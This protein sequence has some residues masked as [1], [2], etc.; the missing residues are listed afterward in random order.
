MTTVAVILSPSVPTHFAID[1]DQIDS[2]W[3]LVL[4]GDS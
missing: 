3:D 1:L 2:V 4:K